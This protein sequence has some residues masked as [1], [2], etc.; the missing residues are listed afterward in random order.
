[1]IRTILCASLAIGVLAAAMPGAAHAACEN[2]TYEGFGAVTQGGR[3][4]TVYRVTNLND[5]GPGSL[6]HGLSEGGRCIVFDVG[7]TISLQ[8]NIYLSAPFVTIDGLSA[9]SP[10]ITLVGSGIVLNG[11]WGEVHDII[12]R[13]LRFRMESSNTVEDGFAMYYGVYNVVLDHNSINGG[14]DENLDFTSGIKNVTVSW[15]IIA[16]PRMNAGN[17]YQV[18]ISEGSERVSYHHNALI[19]GEDR[20]PIIQ[21]TWRGG[22]SVD[23]TADFRN[24][25]VDYTSWGSSVT[26]GAKANLVNNYYTGPEGVPHYRVITVCA[27]SGPYY[28]PLDSDQP[29]VVQYAARAYV[30]GN[31]ANFPTTTSPNAQNTESAPFPAAAVRTTSACEAAADVLASAGA[32][33]PNFGLD[34][35]DRRALAEV[36][37]PTECARAGLPPPPPG[38]LRVHQ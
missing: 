12:I 29:H 14:P 5:S 13:G 38:N 4:R 16:Y 17:E 26:G 3:G 28:C 32:R 35:L 34:E 36:R 23:T 37:V 18:V 19:R 33:G 22:W 31:V 2:P 25:L 10:G 11:Q 30:Q 24:N 8:G 15:N 1:M 9:P 27:E 6:R 21:W 20:N 7:G